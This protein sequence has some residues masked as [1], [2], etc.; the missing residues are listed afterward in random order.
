VT[1][2]PK[3]AKRGKVRV[4][5]TV[6]LA[7]ASAVRAAFKQN[8]RTVASRRGRSISARLA[9]GTYRLEL[10]YRERGHRKTVVRRVRIG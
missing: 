6:K 8:G 4:V 5:C 2:T 9:R 7:G 10:T 3:K 1:C